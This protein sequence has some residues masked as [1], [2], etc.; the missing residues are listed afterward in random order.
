MLPFVSLLFLFHNFFNSCF[1]NLQ[2]FLFIFLSMSP[3]PYILMPQTVRMSI[4]V[5]R[6]QNRHSEFVK[7]EALRAGSNTKLTYVNSFFFILK[8]FFVIAFYVLLLVFIILTITK[9]PFSYFFSFIIVLN[10]DIYRILIL[11][12]LLFLTISRDMTDSVTSV[13][14]ASFS[15]DSENFFWFL[16]CQ[17]TDAVFRHFW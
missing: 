10:Q 6:L 3:I 17:C 13:A 1:S 9:C 2:V 11:I 14:F 12:L 15:V 8:F 7:Q 4:V 5:R 16:F